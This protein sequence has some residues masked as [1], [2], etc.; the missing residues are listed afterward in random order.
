MRTR[1]HDTPGTRTCFPGTLR[2]RTRRQGILR[3]WPRGHDTARP[4][5][6]GHGTA[7]SRTHRHTT[8]CH[9]TLCKRTRC[10]NTL[11]T[12]T[13]HHNTLRTKTRCRSTLRTK[14]GRLPCHPWG[15]PCGC[16]SLR[17]RSHCLAPSG[18]GH[19]ATAPRAPGH[20]AITSSGSGDAV[21]AP[22]GCRYMTVTPQGP[23]HT[24]MA[25]GCPGPQGPRLVQGLGTR[26]APA[27]SLLPTLSQRGWGQRYMHVLVQGTRGTRAHDTSVRACA[28]DRRS[29]ALWCA[30]A[31]VTGRDGVC[32]NCVC[33][34]EPETTRDV[35]VWVFIHVRAP[36]AGAENA[37]RVRV[38]SMGRDHATFL[39]VHV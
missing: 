11:R 24:G 13:H 35:C 7:R 8:H 21:T 17:G 26:P 3:T 19:A 23:G 20:M 2:M 34:H 36:Q 38:H 29:R 6:H 37:P 18:P 30:C 39:S 9:D 4:R 28:H 22:S 12:C 1:C 15:R 33:V 5:I 32:D 27:T 16:D 10:P 31:H 14:T 25:P